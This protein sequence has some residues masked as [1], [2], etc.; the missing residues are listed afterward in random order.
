MESRELQVQIDDAYACPGSCAGCVLNAYERKGSEPSMNAETLNIV[1]KRLDEYIKHIRN[2]VEY[3]NITYGIAD[4][5]IY[6]ED[7]LVDLYIKTA[8]ILKNN[9]LFDSCIFMSSSFIGKQENIMKKLK[10]IK[11]VVDKFGIG[12]IPVAVLDPKALKYQK[13]GNEYKE[14]ILKAKELFSKVDLSINL[15]SEAINHIT[16]LELYDFAVDNKFDEV[17]INWTPTDDNIKMTYFNLNNIKE[18]LI[19]FSK[20]IEGKKLSSSY[21]PVLKRTI[22]SIMCD[23]D[24]INYMG[25]FNFIKKI[26][27]ETISKS[28]HISENADLFPKFE[29][30]GDVPQ[31]PRFGY[32]ELGNLKDNSILELLTKG[33]NL[34]SKR[35]IDPIIKNKSCSSCKYNIICS[36]MG[37]HVYTNVLNKHVKKENNSCPH[38]A[39]DLIDYF[40]KMEEE[41]DEQKKRL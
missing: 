31:S 11:G 39:Y 18:F 1:H 40:Y 3:V 15:S 6:S 25:K 17:T 12:F 41:K 38:V 26:T 20:I 4:H 28:I 29:A 5:F 19:E 37:Y 30:I 22:N 14:N 34:M 16:P 27:E 35:I 2:N 32:K 10:E 13:F 24:N 33:N 7:Y 36:S 21:T 8:T 23:I 9:N